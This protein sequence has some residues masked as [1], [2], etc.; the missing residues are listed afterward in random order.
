[1]LGRGFQ[2]AGGIK[3]SHWLIGLQ[4]WLLSKLFC[5]GT[6]FLLPS[7]CRSPGYFRSPSGVRCGGQFKLLKS[8]C[9]K[10]LCCSGLIFW[11]HSCQW[12]KHLWMVIHPF[13]RWMPFFFCLGNRRT[14]HSNTLVL[15]SCGW[16]GELLL[17]CG[18]TTFLIYTELTKTNI[19]SSPCLVLR[20]VGRSLKLK[21]NLYS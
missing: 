5:L 15:N 4:W 14:L 1:M 13:W 21:L 7:H 20:H 3:L 11:V 2:W 8:V 17:V 6:E 10:Q 19:G 9:V 16:Q 18:F 12:V